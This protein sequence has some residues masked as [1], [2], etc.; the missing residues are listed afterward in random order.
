MKPSVTFLYHVFSANSHFFKIHSAIVNNTMVSVAPLPSIFQGTQDGFFPPLWCNRVSLFAEEQPLWMNS[1]WILRTA[2]HAAARAWNSRA[3][4]T[5]RQPPNPSHK[6]RLVWGKDH[7]TLEQ[8]GVGE[9]EVWDL[10]DTIC[11]PPQGC[12]IE[13]RSDQG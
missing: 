10:T 7:V 6:S 3:P 8:S 4:Q 5:H 11:I 2:A 13:T 12:H 1:S 9:G